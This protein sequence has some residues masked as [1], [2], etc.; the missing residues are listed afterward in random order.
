MNW[1]RREREL[2]WPD[3]SYFPGICLEHRVDLRRASVR[4]G[5]NPA[6]VLTE[7]LPNKLEELH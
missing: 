1:K 6:Q 3:L 4:M 2:S 7:A 5:S